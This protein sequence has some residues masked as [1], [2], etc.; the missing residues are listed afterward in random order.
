MRGAYGVSSLS[1]NGTGGNGAGETIA[2]L[3]PGNDTGLV[4]STSSSF[5]T[6]DLAVFDA[7]YGLANPPSF[8][9]MGV[10]DSTN[11]LTTTLPAAGTGNNDADGEISLDVEWAHVMA[12]QANI[13]LVEGQPG[14]GDIY[15]GLLAIDAAAGSMHICAVSMSFSGSESGNVGNKSTEETYD[16]S[17]FDTPGVVYLASAGDSGA[18]ASG[19]STISSQ[20]PASSVNVLAVGGTTLNVSGNSYSS[21]TTWG[22]GTSSG[23]STNGAG[24]GGLGLEPQPTYQVGKVNG[25][26]TT[27]RAY[28]DISLEGN[29]STGVP[30]YDSPD[31]GAG[32]GWVPGLAGGT[33]LSAPMMA[34]LIA[35]ADQGR[36]LNGLAALNSSGGSGISKSNPNGNSAALDIHTILYGM[37]YANTD[38]HD[39][40][41]GSANGPSSPINYGPK[42]GYDLSS[43]IGSPAANNLL[44]DLSKAST[45][46]AVTSSSSSPGFGQS[47]TFT[48]TITTANGGTNESGTVQFQID[49][50]NVGSPVALSGNT[51]T[52]STSSLGPGSH[53]IV[54]VYSGDNN[55]T[56]ST[57]PTFTQSV[58]K[59][60][61]A[62]AVT[63]SDSSPA[64][65]QPVT[66]TATVTPASGS[67]E[68]GT[69]QFTV[70]GSSVSTFTISN[71]TATYTTSSLT[72]GSHTIMAI[73]SGDPNFA[74][75]T[76]PAFSQN[77]QVNVSSVVV[78]GNNAALAGVQRSMVDSIVY[79]FSEGVNLA[80]NAFT[81]AQNAYFA[82]GT[83]PTLSWSAVSG[84]N[85]TQWVVT[86]SG[87]G[88]TSGGSI[89]DGVY[90]ITLNGEAVTSVAA[91]A[92][93]AANETDTFYCLYGDAGGYGKVNNAD[94]AA[95]AGTYGLKSG[96]A[97]FLAYFDTQGVGKISNSEYALFA[98]N[99]GNGFASVG[100]YVTI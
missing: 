87:S 41:S 66:F 84:T 74:G 98:A 13:L 68:T 95:F 60:A 73:Y 2:I 4:D 8:T 59:A 64:D 75:S 22:A 88:V 51:A 52:Y 28:P 39:I 37:G 90:D 48:A 81:I 79:T 18:Y 71:G 99:Y 70:D 26:T 20:Y 55:Y 57:S 7:Y 16:G 89:G 96:A 36:A 78:N 47:A 3:D 77:V 45:A 100:N 49:G 29:P 6:S 15:N 34:G 12:P 24:G 72:A 19:T 11:T 42:T 44:V 67:G 85:N 14:F 82:T 25:L 50:S 97:N 91:G 92:A 30:V 23:T 76:S 35:D 62:T 61:T 31:Y 83:V 80:S 1:F 43:G 69:F 65:G 93:L 9:K 46:T 32:T 58:V 5:S 21:E 63:S 54:A 10:N 38:F 53:S 40:T 27:A 17:R 86:F 56:T 94:Y 33:S